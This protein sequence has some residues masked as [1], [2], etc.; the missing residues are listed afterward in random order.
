MTRFDLPEEMLWKAAW[1]EDL[2]ARSGNEK[3]FP[4]LL[5]SI[6]SFFNSHANY[7]NNPSAYALPY[8]WERNPGTPVNLNYVVDLNRK[9]DSDSREELALDVHR[10]LTVAGAGG[11]LS[12]RYHKILAKIDNEADF[13]VDRVPGRFLRTWL[14]TAIQN[15]LEKRREG[16]N[17]QRLYDSLTQILGDEPYST[18]GVLMTCGRED[19]DITSELGR[20]A[21]GVQGESELR[22]L[23]RRSDLRLAVERFRLIPRERPSVSD[24]VRRRNSRIFSPGELRAGIREIVRDRRAAITPGFLM[25]CA[26]RAFPDLYPVIKTERSWE[27]RIALVGDARDLDGPGV[28]EHTY[29]IQQFE[30]GEMP[31]SSRTEPTPFTPSV[32]FEDTEQ[33]GF[34][35]LEEQ[36]IAAAVDQVLTNLTEAEKICFANKLLGHADNNLIAAKA[37]LERTQYVSR[38]SDAAQEKIRQAASHMTDIMENRLNSDGSL[39]SDPIELT[40]EV[41]RRVH[42]DLKQFVIGES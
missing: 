1:I 14:H 4:L 35:P 27:D 23:N 9:W 13:V 18:F 11:P 33:A 12:L 38:R 19:D 6:T 26:E 17:H 22:P 16:S 37:G 21:Y 5:S 39:A 40:V 28:D 29:D 42:L 30:D 36:A 31:Q 41:L 10:A 2:H 24:D 7:R 20:T 32:Q 25:L 15:M 34:D 8:D 3:W